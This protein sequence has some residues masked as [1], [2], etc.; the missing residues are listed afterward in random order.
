MR[1]PFRTFWRVLAIGLILSPVGSLRA[2]FAEL[3]DGGAIRGE[4]VKQPI[5][6]GPGNYVFHTLG[7]AVVEFP[8]DDVARFVKRRKI[9]EEFEVR[10]ESAAGDAIALWDVSEWAREQGLRPERS[11]AL[12]ALVLVDPAN[13][14][15]HRGLGH[16]QQD[17]RWMSRDEANTARGL[18][19]HKGKWVLPQ[20]VDLLEEAEAQ[21]AEEKDWYRKV[22]QWHTW[23]RDVQRPERQATGLAHLRA[24]SAPA[25]VPAVAR[26]LGRDPE[27]QVRLL[28][29]HIFGQTAGE[30][31]TLPLVNQVLQ[32]VS[33]AVRTTAIGALRDRDPLRP[34]QTFQRALKHELNFVVNRAAAALGVLGTDEQ[35][36]A[37]IDALT[38]EHR[39]TIMVQD[40]AST[41]GVRSDG[42]FAP[43]NV[44]VV[45]PEIA[46]MLATGQLP[47]GVNV[48][49]APLP[50]DNM[51]QRAVTIL[52]KEQ[53]PDV[54]DA[55]GKLTGQNLGF[56]ETA[57]KA[58]WR[59][60]QAAAKAPAP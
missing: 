49:H 40:P 36:P 21:S 55:L 47:Q 20:E 12:E 46:G 34:R 5:L 14:S 10:L 24:I 18:V 27:E 41:I 39:Y 1:P 59:R 15:A 29:T 38:T 60:R 25:A 7:G 37:L 48:Q 22:K 17:G 30:A 57:W 35:V 58:W 43:T 32:D 28:A 56:D 33:A 3:I 6:N 53:N 42:Q 54:L 26:H 52:R 19:K 8:S 11:R 50:G 4:C 16:I 45:P 2:D 23:L 9:L 51:R 13:V 31:P 44:P